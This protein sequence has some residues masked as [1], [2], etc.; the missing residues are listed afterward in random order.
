M[1]IRDQYVIVYFG[2]INQKYINAGLVPNEETH[3]FLWAISQDGLVFEKKGIALDSR[4][5]EFKGWLDGPEFT[6]WDDG[7]I[8]LYFWLY[9]GIYHVEFKDNK[10]SQAAQFEYTTEAGNPFPQNPPGDP[11]LAKINGEWFMYYG[12]HLKEIYFATYEK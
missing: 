2:A 4:N 12:Q 6:K 1:K 10:F 7:S 3:L 9:R 11:T 5:S 8:R